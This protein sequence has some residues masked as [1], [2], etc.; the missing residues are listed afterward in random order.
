MGLT[1]HRIALVA[2]LAFGVWSFWPTLELG[3]A[4][5]DYM[6]VAVAEGR[7]AAPRDRLDVFNFAGGSAA[8]VQATQRLG[9]LPWFAPQQ[10]RFSFLRPL[11]STLWWVDRALFGDALWAYHVHSI[12][13]WVL[14]ALAASALYRRLLPLSAAAWATAFFAL[15]QSQHMP[16]LWLCNRGALYALL[17]GVLGLH[18][19]VRWREQGERWGPW[20]VLA[21]TSLA[22]AFGEWA[23]AMLSYVFAYEALGQRGAWWPRLRALAPTAVPAGLFLLLRAAL[24]YGVRGSGTYVDP[25]AEPLAFVQLLGHRLPVL[26][27]DVLFDLPAAWWDHGSPLRDR[28]LA[29]GLFAPPVWTALPE[30]RVYHL[31]LGLLAVAALVLGLRALARTIAMEERRALAWLALGAV[32]ALVPVAGSFP[33]TRLTL[34]A[35]FGFAPTFA[36]ALRELGRVMLRASMPLRAFLLR[37]C[38]AA[39]ILALQLLSPLRGNLRAQVDNFAILR[40]WVL[41]AELDPERVAQQ[42]V[43][44]LYSSEFVTTVFFA[45]TWGYHGKPLPRSLY[46]V[47]MAPSAHDIER[48]A[49]NELEL[50]A[51][52][53]TFLASAGEDMFRSPGLALRTG[54]EVALPGMTVRVTRTL[55]GKPQTLRVRFEHALEHP[56][57]VFL[58][59]DEDGL[60]RV[61]L[62]ALGET[63]RVPRP[64]RPSWLALQLAREERRNGAPPQAFAFDPVPSFVAWEP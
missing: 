60:R 16:V 7:F 9:S 11:S 45:Y 47:S 62:P 35:M 42:R 19:H 15:D 26:I 6:A 2:I 34:A 58:G 54:D 38:L 48:I 56:G 49:D 52:G 10:L 40:Q 14:L 61:Q 43:F 20:A 25:G 36:L 30:W 4:A 51:L 22:L 24:G 5:D 64:A 12:A 3:L 55:E 28:V 57:Y 41:Q 18:A 21:C 37:Y 46:P 8:D 1:A 29:S 53:G 44:L 32:L 39:A 27:A 50:R 59:A 63:L 13:L 33:S 23:L 31:L 17:L